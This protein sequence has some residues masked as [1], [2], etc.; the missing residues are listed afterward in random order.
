MRWFFRTSASRPGGHDV[1]LF[2][3]V[4]EQQ[5]AAILSSNHFQNYKNYKNEKP[6]M[7][8]C[9]ANS[10]NSF[11]RAACKGAFAQAQFV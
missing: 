4:E 8:C 3:F 5:K 10:F 6:Q 9:F 1:L 11:L 2:R 7:L